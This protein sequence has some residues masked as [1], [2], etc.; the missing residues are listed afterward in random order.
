MAIL[1]ANSTGNFNTAATWDRPS[2]TPG[3]HAT[4]NRTVTTAGVNSATFTA[5][6]ITDSATGVW[7]WVVTYPAAGRNFTCELFEGG[8]A[9]G[10]IATI[11]QT[12]MPTSVGWIYFRLPV[13]YLFTS[14]AAGHYRWQLKSTTANSGTVAADTAGTAFSYVSTD[15]RTQAPTTSDRCWIAPH[16][17]TTAITVTVDGTTG[18]IRG[19]GTIQTS[20]RTLTQGLMLGGSLTNSLAVLKFD[21]GASATLSIA[22]QITVFDGGEIQMGTVATP[23]PASLTA[24]LFARQL[25][26]TSQGIYQYG[27]G[28]IIMQGAPRTFYVT[29]YVSGVGTAASPLVVSDAVDWNVGDLVVTTA[30]SANATNYNETESRFIITKNSPTSYVLSLTSGGAEAAFTFTHNTNAKVLLLTRNVNYTS[31]IGSSNNLFVT[32]STTAG[33]VDIDWARI[34]NMGTSGGTPLISAFTSGFMIGVITTTEVAGVDY[35]VFDQSQSYGLILNSSTAQTFTGNIFYNSQVGSATPTAAGLGVNVNA[36]NITFV[37]HYFIRNQR[38]AVDY[39]GINCT[40]TNPTVISN[41]ING[42]A[43]QGGFFLTNGTPCIV[44][45][46]NFHANRL[47]DIQLNTTAGT[48]FTNCEISNKGSSPA[49]FVVTA[50][51]SNNVLFDNCNVG[52]TVVGSGYLTGA[53]GATLVAFNKLNQT[54]NNHRWYTEYGSAQSTG[55]TLSD[56]LVRTSGRLGV[57]INSEDLTTG[58]RYEYKVP[59]VVG[60]AVNAL[61]FIQK[62]I[63]FGTS[64][65]TVEIFLP[66][67]TAADAT[68]T[69][70]DTTGSWLTYALA[71]NY[72]GAVPLFATIR[73]TA[74]TTTSAAYVYVC[75]ILNGTNTITDLTTWDRG[76]PSPIMFEQLGDAGAVWAVLLSSSTTAGTFGKLVQNLLDVPKFIALK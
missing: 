62:N 1:T 13:A 47:T 7:V 44:N 33:Q 25:S 40:F 24:T 55:A 19:S 46:G 76:Q 66:G 23:Y 2:N 29:T 50:N 57:R 10:S 72:L 52:S 5:P 9:T 58:F 27:T 35:C 56:T 67:S 32:V 3:L 59:A 11:V 37:D 30:T 68:Q 41:N 38:Q 34:L 12:D 71:A 64:V 73:I 45:G 43:N 36:K 21:T 74:K 28:R 42:N 31:G 61:G 69:M 48:T 26:G 20:T 14:V 16:N 63:A 22:S 54:A 4:T 6:A 60:R 51:A 8:V 53:N 65:C 75:D 15:N 49:G 18:D 70:S 17:C 39:R